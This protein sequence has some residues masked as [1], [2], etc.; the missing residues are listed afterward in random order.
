MSGEVSVVLVGIG[1]YGRNYVSALLD[2][3]SAVPMRLV[4]AVDPA[5]ER[6]GRLDELREKGVRIC[7]TLEE[8]YAG[9]TADLAVVS[10]PIPLHCPLT[11]LALEHGSHVL[12]EKPLCATVQEVAAM[13][14]ARDV[15]QRTV[16]IGYQ[17]SFS[18]AVH[19]LKAD[20]RAGL[21]GAPLRLKTLVLWPRDEAYYGRN[22]W[23]GRLHDNA[24]RWVL[25]SPVN[26]AAAHYLH[27]MLY[28][29]G[30]EPD[31]SAVPVEIEAELYRA[32]DIES[33]DT[34]ALRVRTSGG[35]E[36]LF[37]VS[38]AVS[39]ETGPVFTF[40][41]ERAQVRYSRGGEIVADFREG[42]IRSYGSP[43]AEPR[44]KLW[45]A[46][47]AA[48]DGAA[49]LCG[50]EA[51]RAHT[52]CVNGAHE[53]APDIAEFP[54][55]LIEVHG[56]EGHR[57]TWVRGLGD[58]LTDGDEAGQLPCQRGLPWSRQGRAVDLRDY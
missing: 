57:L 44:R 17:W 48:R 56:A 46:A 29:L 11:C 3:V 54:V 12:C 25:D 6:C 21:F 53:S 52:L 34:A 35:A 16:A 36:L 4:G 23:A 39:E 42:P 33:F 27:N 7:D 28:V 14:S 41:F 9:G 2:E 1:G 31:R 10:A 22:A 30:D 26:N 32:N 18:D 43:D 47:L 38:H 50:I 5:P 15:A 45:D 55:N 20:V 13:A 8:F 40:E 49:V 37:Y 51:A 24:G 58:V 19:R